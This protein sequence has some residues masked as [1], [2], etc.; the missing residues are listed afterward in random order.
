MKDDYF[1]GSKN[2]GG[3]S[4]RGSSCVNGGGGQALSSKSSIRV[5]NAAS[6]S[7][8]S[9]GG[10]LAHDGAG[11]SGAG[12]GAAAT[13]NPPVSATAASTNSVH[14]THKHLLRS[15]VKLASGEHPKE[16]LSSSKLSSK[17]YKKD[18]AA[19]SASS[20]RYVSFYMLRELDHVQVQR[21]YKYTNHDIC[22]VYRHRS[23]SRARKPVAE[24][25]AATANVQMSNND[26]SHNSTSLTPVTSTVASAQLNSTLAEDEAT[27][28]APASG[29][30]NPNFLIDSISI[31][32]F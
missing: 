10:A 7:V 12:A 9:G 32:F 19:G 25:V 14:A 11:T 21:V 28:N 20:S 30:N 17:H 5:G 31:F 1:V 18:S 4:D 23:S 2:Q 8:E 24:G 15:R 26:P 3:S 6:N 22:I 16:L 13:A 29:T 27:S